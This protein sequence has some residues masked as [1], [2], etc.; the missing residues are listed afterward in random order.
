MA[1]VP[2]LFTVN[3]NSTPEP[4]EKKRESGLPEA[5]HRRGCVGGVAM[6]ADQSPALPTPHPGSA[7]YVMLCPVKAV[8]VKEEPTVREA[9]ALDQATVTP[10]SSH[11]LT[12]AQVLLPFKPKA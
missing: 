3:V 1:P 4:P 8:N 11:F 12:P 9:L 2:L 7:A 10:R 6:A 5:S